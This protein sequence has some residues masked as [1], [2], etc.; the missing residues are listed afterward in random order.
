M[1]SLTHRLGE[2]KPVRK[3]K[4]I[5]SNPQPVQDFLESCRIGAYAENILAPPGF[6]G[7]FRFSLPALDLYIPL[8][9]DGLP[10]NGLRNRSPERLFA[11]V[12]RAHAGVWRGG[13]RAGGAADCGGVPNGPRGSG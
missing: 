4:P 11:F 5:I 13:L 10:G 9:A 1:S 8:P 3:I 2:W 12:G 7:S 6:L